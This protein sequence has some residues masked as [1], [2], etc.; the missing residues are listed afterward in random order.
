MP[1]NINNIVSS[2]KGDLARPSRFDVYIPAPFVLLP[3]RDMINKTKGLS[4]R[5]E[6][7]EMPGRSLSTI[8]RK[9]GSTPTFKVPYQSIYNEIPM[10]FIVD[11]DMTVKLFFDLWMDSINPTINYNFRYPR[12]YIT[13]IAITQYDAHNEIS[14]RSILLNAY[15]MD[16][17][18]MDLDWT[19]DT[20]HKLTVV[21]AYT[22]WAYGTFNEIGKNTLT[23]ILS[24]I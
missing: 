1:A 6:M 20:Y 18:Q 4:L 24:S 19:S 7:S 3:M 17:Q 2:F 22:N 12:D 11:D 15:P 14:Y 5:C 8:E 10:T 9:I 13:D 23:Q 21:F 16:V